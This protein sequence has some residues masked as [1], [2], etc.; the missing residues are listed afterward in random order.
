MADPELLALQRR[1]CQCL[2][3]RRTGVGPI[4]SLLDRDDIRIVRGGLHEL[5]DRRVR[6]ER[7]MQQHISFAN[8][9]KDVFGRRELGGDAR[10]ESRLLQRR[11]GDASIDL[12]E[13]AE[14]RQSARVED[15]IGGDARRRH[16]KSDDCLVR[17]RRDFDPDDFLALASLQLGLDRFEQILHFVFG[18]CDVGVAH[19]AEGNGFLDDQAREKQVEVN[20]DQRFDRD[21]AR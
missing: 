14:L 4:E 18:Q 19:D 7:P 21:V 10:I 16:Q 11:L 6:V 1:F 12:H 2:D 8:D 17:T 20:F 3:D 13:V 15:V 5:D 9:R